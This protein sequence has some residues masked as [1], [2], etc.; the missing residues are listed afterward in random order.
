MNYPEPIGI[1]PLWRPDFDTI[2]AIL[3]RSPSRFV[4]DQMFRPHTK[5]GD[6]LNQFKQV[7]QENGGWLTA[8]KIAE[9][10]RRNK[11]STSLSLSRFCREKQ[12]RY[13]YNNEGTREYGE[14]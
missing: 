13:R 6:A 8:A 5:Y 14:I 11:R 1:N 3:A 12:L 2:T 10:I 7:I 9:I 4:G